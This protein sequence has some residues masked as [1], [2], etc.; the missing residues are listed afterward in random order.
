MSGTQAEGT[1]RDIAGQAEEAVGHVTGDSNTEMRG[2]VRQIAGQTQSAVGEAVETVRE[3][4][5]EQPL[6]AVLLA[7]GIGLIAGMLIARR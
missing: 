4:A 2:K 5:A 3:M 6:M 7:A 1:I